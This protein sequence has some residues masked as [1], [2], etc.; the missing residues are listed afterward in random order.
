[1][2]RLLKPLWVLLALVFLV[3]AWL[4]DR[5]APLVARLVALIPWLKIKAAVAA[6]IEAL[7]PTATLAVF[8]LP[9]A[10][11]LPVKFLG[12]WLL[13]R[14]AWLGAVA[15]LVAAKVVGLGLTAFIFDVTRPKLLQLAWFRALYQRVLAWRDWAHAQVDPIVRALRQRLAGLVAPAT[16]Q[17]RR[18]LQRLG[19]RPSG[20]GLK[21]ARRIRRRIHA[22][23]A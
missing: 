23:A 11:L 6:R 19:W 8:L 20:R 16:R 21:L 7:P 2:T 14:G 22:R 3:E 5:L 15:L 9:V 13:A 4:W 12:L 18:A 10:V 1:M 17:V